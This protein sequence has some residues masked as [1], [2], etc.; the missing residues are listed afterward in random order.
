MAIDG[1]VAAHAGSLALPQDAVAFM[2]SG[3]GSQKPGMGADLLDVPEVKAAFDL[4]SS[5]FGFDVA[6]VVCD[7]DP[8]RINDTRFAQPALCALSVGIARALEARGVAPD[9]VL[10]F[11]LGQIGALAVS[12]MLSDQ[13]TFALVA[14]RTRLMA[15]ASEAHPGAMSALLKGT[16]EEV[17]QLCAECAQG[18][19]LVPA[20]FNSPGQVVVAGEPEAIE[21][22]EAAWTAQGKRAS[23][24]KTSGAF[25][26]P[27]MQEAAEGLDAYLSHV[28]FS[29]A[30][31]PLICNV[32]ARPLSA[33]DARDHL[34]RQLVSPVRFTQCVQT[35][36]AAGA[37][38]FIEVGFG[39]VL[40]NLVKRIDKE[41]ARECVQDRPSLDACVQTYSKEDNR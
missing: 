22:A 13:D 15:Q 32:D 11:S 33:A 2:L 39:G 41:A 9:A 18:Q 8:T 26:S 23:R 6:D 37:Q 35:L 28:G 16:D 36:R 30:R 27:L 40:R 38:T 20:N 21:R 34:V 24:L 4:A 5:T 7:D 25:H 19:V 3:Q 12:G 17:E 31:V 29:E 14:E 10:G 1:N